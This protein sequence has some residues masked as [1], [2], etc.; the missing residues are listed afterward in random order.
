MTGAITAYKTH[1]E[2]ARLSSTTIL[3]S[4]SPG[5]RSKSVM[6]ATEV[7]PPM[8]TCSCHRPACMHCHKDG[9]LA[10]SCYKRHTELKTHPSQ[11]RGHFPTMILVL[12]LV[13]SLVL[14]LLAYLLAGFSIL[15]V[16]II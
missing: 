13:P 12:N 3:V 15:I 14:R 2:T 7:A 8:T 16:H 10:G 9:H 5:P 11:G 4:S 1:Q 6:L